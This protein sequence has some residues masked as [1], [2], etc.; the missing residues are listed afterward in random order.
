MKKNVPLGAVIAFVLPLVLYAVSYAIF[1][2]ETFGVCMVNPCMG[3]KSIGFTVAVLLM[4]ITTF[5][6]GPIGLIFSCYILFGVYSLTVQFREKGRS[7][8]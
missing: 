7:S 2:T 8:L 6:S 4:Q 1:L 5:G 3:W